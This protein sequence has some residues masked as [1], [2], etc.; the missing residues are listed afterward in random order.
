[1]DS[2]PQPERNCRPNASIL[3]ARRKSVHEVPPLLAGQR[4]FNIIEIWEVIQFDISLICFFSDNLTSDLDQTFRFREIFI[5]AKL[6]GEKIIH[7]CNYSA[8]TRQFVLEISD[9][10]GPTTPSHQIFLVF[11]IFHLN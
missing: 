10:S 3:L 5:L 9:E 7:A 1:M 11:P 6:F 4:Y 8:T 2:L